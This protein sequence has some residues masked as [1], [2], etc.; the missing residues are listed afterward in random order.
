MDIVRIES[1][2]S[3]T[4]FFKPLYVDVSQKIILKHTAVELRIIFK[5]GCLKIF[6]LL[7][8]I[9]IHTRSNPSVV[10]CR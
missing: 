4:Y 5:N 3:H 8:S 10:A 6:C 2:A 1:G 9:P 7:P